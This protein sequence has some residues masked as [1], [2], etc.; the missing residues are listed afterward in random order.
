MNYFAEK[1][2]GI[3]V[4]FLCNCYKKEGYVI[5]RGDRKSKGRFCDWY[6]GVTEALS[7]LSLF[8]IDI[9]TDGINRPFRNYFSLISELYFGR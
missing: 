3:R 9:K 2:Q 7:L 1:K 6:F 5:R 4:V 8:Y